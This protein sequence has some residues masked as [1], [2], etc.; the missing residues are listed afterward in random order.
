MLT[1]AVMFD[2]DGT[3]WDA[4]AASAEG[5]S[6]AL[7]RL[8][9]PG[10]VNA[11]QIAAVAGSPYETCVDTLLPGLR[12]R[13]PRLI[14]V[15]SACERASVERSGGAFY[16]GALET[17]AQLSLG[18][19]VF[20]ISNCQDWYLDL[21]LGFS[22]L[23]P[24]LAGVDCYGRSGLTKSEMLARMKRSHSCRAPVY[25]GDTAGDEAAAA[26]AGIT[27]IHAAWG[28]GQPKGR[29]LTVSSFAELVSSLERMDDER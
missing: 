11:E 15:L 24:L 26:L 14:D 9:L 8:G 7:E 2:I 16:S 3:L 25:V 6:Q 23:G 21:F 27:H 4:S 13:C 5:W 12:A 18:F 17:V 22:R 28:F 10:S 29:P 20:L 19:D 1:D